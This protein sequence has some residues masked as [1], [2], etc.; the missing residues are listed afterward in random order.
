MRQRFVVQRRSIKS[1]EQCLAVIFPI[2]DGNRVVLEA[3]FVENECKD[4]GDFRSG[5]GVLLQTTQAPPVEIG[6]ARPEFK[7]VARLVDQK[8]GVFILCLLKRMKGIVFRQY[9]QSIG[10][11]ENFAPHVFMNP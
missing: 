7:T 11:T 6:Y 1:Y 2:V 5:W 8:E 4:S 10:L 3:D 9:F